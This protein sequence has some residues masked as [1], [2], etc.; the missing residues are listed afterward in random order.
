MFEKR[1]DKF[2]AMNRAQQKAESRPV[3]VVS[4]VDIFALSGVTPR[5]VRKE[6]VN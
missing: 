4:D 3:K 1:A 2:R 5:V 6:S